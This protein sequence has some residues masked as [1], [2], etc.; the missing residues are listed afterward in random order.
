M[1]YLSKSSISFIGNAVKFRNPDIAHAIWVFPTAIVEAKN[2]EI[3]VRGHSGKTI[4]SFRFADLPAVETAGFANALELIDSW[5][6]ES[7]FSDAPNATEGISIA[8][9]VN[10]IT[11]TPLYALS[12]SRKGAIVS[13]TSGEVLYIRF[14]DIASDTLFSILMPK[15][16][17]YEVPSFAVK[18][19]LH[20]IKDKGGASNIQLTTF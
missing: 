11:S 19:S 4:D 15:D 7:R 13:N 2:G 9:S 10:S 3:E 12:N 17:L 8:L 6:W 16:S 5:G 14:G 18:S 20:A 1:S